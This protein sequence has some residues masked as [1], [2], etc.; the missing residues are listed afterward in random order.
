MSTMDTQIFFNYRPQKHCQT[1]IHLNFFFLFFFFPKKNLS[2][3]HIGFSKEKNEHIRL[4]ASLNIYVC[5]F[6]CLLLKGRLK[7]MPIYEENLEGT[8]VLFLPF[9]FH[10]KVTIVG[11]IVKLQII[12]KYFV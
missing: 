9:S 8:S 1:H 11:K 6:V 5:V 12:C 7:I 10:V 2:Y 3:S 4:L